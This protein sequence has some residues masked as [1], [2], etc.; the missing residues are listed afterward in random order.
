VTFSGR[1]PTKADQ[2][3]LDALKRGTCIA[4]LQRFDDPPDHVPEIHHLDG[5]TKPGAHQRTIALCGW[6]HRSDNW[7]LRRATLREQYG[8]SLA[9]GSKPFHEAFGSNALL[10]TIQNAI[11]RGED[12]RAAA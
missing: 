7:G 1:T 2:A 9:E 3:R 10:L 4:C 11:L 6:H 12:W 5:K 8:P